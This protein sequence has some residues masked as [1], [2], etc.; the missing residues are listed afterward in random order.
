MLGLVHVGVLYLYFPSLSSLLVHLIM[1]H[2]SIYFHLPFESYLFW[3]M[4][5]VFV[6]FDWESSF[7]ECQLQTIFDCHRSY[8][9]P[10]KSEINYILH[11]I[12]YITIT[13][14]VGNCSVNYRQSMK[15]MPSHPT[16]EF[17]NFI[18]SLSV[19]GVKAFWKIIYSTKFYYK[20][21]FYIRRCVFKYCEV[22]LVKSRTGTGKVNCSLYLTFES[23]ENL[24]YFRLHR[25]YLWLQKSF[26][27]HDIL[28]LEC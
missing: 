26:K 15:V 11:Y 14:K 10:W 5:F 16:I 27:L 21:S 18:Q 25:Y 1:P 22:I 3:I 9:F 24:S 4:F 12:Y 20:N 17:M 19:I 23:L 6:L 28:H 2:A 13:F 7:E 8:S